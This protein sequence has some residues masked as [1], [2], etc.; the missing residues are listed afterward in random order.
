MY[1]FFSWSS[2]PSA[3]RFGAARARIH[4]SRRAI[5]RKPR[6]KPGY[7][8]RIGFAATPARISH[9]RR[10]LPLHGRN[11]RGNDTAC[12]CGRHD[13]RDDIIATPQTV[14]GDLR[15]DPN[16]PLKLVSAVAAELN[17]ALSEIAMS[18]QHLKTFGPREIQEI[19]DKAGL[20]FDETTRLLTALR[21]HREQERQARSAVRKANKQKRME[22]MIHIDN[23]GGTG[24]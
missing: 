24:L 20:T 6:L 5:F 8:S 7:G 2:R 23:M 13:S 14:I 4:E 17:R 19:A 12:L 15:A 10:G 16:G 11:D 1:G 18:A 3:L 9:T 22:A 21:K